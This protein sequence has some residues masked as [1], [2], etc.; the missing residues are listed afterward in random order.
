MKLASENLEFEK[1]NE[2]KNTLEALV[3]YDSNPRW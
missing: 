1:A 2:L 3:N